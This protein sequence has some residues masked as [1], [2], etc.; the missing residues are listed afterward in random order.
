MMVLALWSLR[1]Y[2]DGDFPMIKDDIERARCDLLSDFVEGKA[3]EE[4]D[5]RI[6]VALL[7]ESYGGACNAIWSI[8]KRLMEQQR[9]RPRRPGPVR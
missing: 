3:V 8:R 2:I 7:M 5:L 6:A 4:K 1:R 9:P